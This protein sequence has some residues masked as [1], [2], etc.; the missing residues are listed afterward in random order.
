[1]NKLLTSIFALIAQA[2][3]VL[4]RSPG[5]GWQNF[6]RDVRRHD[7]HI[8]VPA[9]R[10][11]FFAVRRP[12]QQ[13]ADEAR[14]FLKDGR[15]FYLYGDGT[16]LP[17]MMGGAGS[18]AILRRAGMGESGSPSEIDAN[19]KIRWVDDVL[20]NMSDKEADMLKYLG[21]FSNFAFNNTKI[22][23]VEDDVWNR[24][25]SLGAGTVLASGTGTGT[26]TLAA[27][28]NHRYPVGTVLFN[29]TKGEHV[30]IESI[31][32]GGATVVVRRDIGAA[33]DES[34]TAWVAADEVI[35][36]GHAMNETDAWVAR[37]GA[38]FN[39]PFNLAQISHVAIDVT[40]RRMETALYGLRGTDLDKVSADTLAEEF[41][42]LEGAAVHGVRQSGT[43]NI[44]ATFGGLK[45][46]ITSAN[47]ATVTDLN[48]AA[49]TRKDIDDLLQTLYRAVGAGKMAKTI[50]IGPWGHRKISSFFSA[51]ERLGPMANE[52]GVVIDRFNTSFG[53]IEV[54]LHQ[55]LALDEMIFINRDMNKIGH[56]G[57]RGRPHLEEAVAVNSSGQTGP[58]IRRVYYSD[59]SMVVKGVQGEGRIVE[60]ATTS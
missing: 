21:G 52:A 58:F 16:V 29:I 3:S 57:Q 34:T 49:L 35:V 25:P 12:V 56:H 4:D 59:T 11:L 14:A 36:A 54:M 19:V 7:F 23:W 6:S 51:A 31:D 50:L 33:V 24:R 43:A 22:E 44:P 26:L 46:F 27:G 45:N 20:G 15:V 13:A 40:Y 5:C 60:F 17:A 37:P 9:F 53:V 1:M 2:A 39:L 10:R 42:A 47:G 48:G 32:S 28:T 41:V 8:R 38:I 18:T 55:A 30:R